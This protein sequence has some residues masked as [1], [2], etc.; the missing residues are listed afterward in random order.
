METRQQ[1]SFRAFI[2]RH[3]V[4][5]FYVLVFALQVGLYLLAFLGTGFLGTGTEQPTSVAD[6]GGPLQYLA[7]LPGSLAVAMAAI[8]VIALAFGRVGLRELRSRLFRWRVGIHWYAV[9]LLTAPLLMTALL[10]TLSLTSQAFL[11]TVITMDDIASLIMAVVV[12]GLLVPFFEELGWT[13][14]ATHE[15]RKR[16][17]VVATGL[18]VGL[19]WGLWHVPLYMATGSGNIPMALYVPVMAFSILLPF[20]VLMVWVYD[21][22]QSVLMAMLMHLSITVYPLVF[23]NSPEMVGGPDFIFNLVVGAT[24]WVLVV[25]LVAADRRERSRPESGQAWHD[26]TQPRPDKVR[27]PR[28]TR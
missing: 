25:L 10:Y 2:E 11:P 9:A 18:I 7:L 14:F 21:H 6:L 28:G 24:L 26:V 22:T 1:R 13:G 3:A 19:L 4:L 5:A 12:V 15:L 8:T 23:L 17:G 16:H 27:R 20:R